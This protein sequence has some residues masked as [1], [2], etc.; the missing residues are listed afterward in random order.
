MPTP[1]PPFNLRALVR[2]VVANS[3][4]NDPGDLAAE[5]ARRIQPDDMET[6]LQQSLRVFVRQILSEQRPH[7]IAPPTS[8][9]VSSRFG[10]VAPA[11]N[12]SAKVAAIRDG[13][14]RHL[15]A[16]Y[17]VGDG[18]WAQ[19][20]DCGR[21]QLDFISTFLD[22]QAAQKQAK[23]R[24]IRRLAEAVTEHD[25]NRVRDLP[26]DLLMVAFGEAA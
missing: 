24:S 20:G 7:I 9:V 13:W 11:T 10:S 12:R 23:A 15:R 8:P 22:E 1:R 5:V 16:R 19:L 26:A 17:H 6:A 3:T 18:E 21:E 25:V 2:E 4:M 14:Q